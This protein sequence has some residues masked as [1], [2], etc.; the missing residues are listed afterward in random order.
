MDNG[1]DMKRELFEIGIKLYSDFH[2]DKGKWKDSVWYHDCSSKHSCTWISC[3]FSPCL[4]VSL[5][6]AS[7][8]F[9][10]SLPFSYHAW[11]CQRGSSD[12]HSSEELPTQGG[13]KG[14]QPSRSGSEE[15]VQELFEVGVHP[16]LNTPSLEQ[17]SPSHCTGTHDESTASEILYLVSAVIQSEWICDILKL[18]HLNNK[19]SIFFVC[20]IQPKMSI[21]LF[22]LFE[23]TTNGLVC[24][25]RKVSLK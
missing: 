24:L 17:P 3:V 6:P 22:K 18:S 23:E 13:Y 2:Y 21:V 12:S 9:N 19:I 4:F 16:Q 20:F 7:L 11:H 14:L 5:S 8:I 15:G 10:F 1:R 25:V